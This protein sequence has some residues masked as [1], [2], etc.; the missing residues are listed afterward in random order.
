VE[1]EICNGDLRISD[2][3]YGRT[4]RIVECEACGF[5]FADPLP[6]SELVRLY[7][8]LEDPD[9]SAGSE[10]RIRPFRRIL[11]R[12]L[13][14]APGAR[15]VLDV[16]AGI[17]LLCRAARELGLEATGVEPSSW[18]VKMA[19]A[20]EGVEV[21]Q[22]SYPH[23]ALQGRRFDILTLI[24]VIEHV[25]D[26]L[27]LLRNLAAALNPGGI[28]V[29]T[30]PDASSLAARLLGRRWWHYRVAHVCYFNRQTMRS[31]LQNTRLSLERQ[32]R[33]TWHFSVGYVAE[34]L[35]RY[36]PVGPLRRKLSTTS[37]GRSIFSW[38]VP[39]NLHDSTTYYSRK[40]GEG[41]HR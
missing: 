7:A 15:T 1:G 28:L 29:V 22:G 27:G 19:S 38:T 6:S 20:L 9:Y 40:P 41:P 36:L 26:P 39:V 13:R 23:P 37:W 34:R 35:E 2:S 25:T 4:A 11:R 21:L 32:E 30:T 12:C 8:E 31:A 24:D 3:H 33:Y 14:M 17:G 16:G 5:R 18:A 10:G